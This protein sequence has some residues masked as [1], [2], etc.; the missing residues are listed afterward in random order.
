MTASISVETSLLKLVAARCSVE[1]VADAGC[2]C[3][4]LVASTDVAAGEVLLTLPWRWALTVEGAVRRLSA[5]EKSGRSLTVL[6]L[7]AVLELAKTPSPL[8]PPG[9]GWAL[10]LALLLLAELRE[11]RSPLARYV[12]TLPA[13]AG[14]LVSAIAL[15]PPAGACAALLT[16][17]QRDAFGPPALAAE[18]RAEETRQ[19]QLHAL[20]FG[21]SPAVTLQSFIWAGALVSSRALS[22]AA[23][24]GSLRCLLPSVDLCNHSSRDGVTASLRLRLRPDG[25]PLCVELASTRPLRRGGEVRFHY[26]PRPLRR[27]A[28]TYGFLPC[29]EGDAAELYEECAVCGEMCERGMLVEAADEEHGGILRLAEVRLG[30]APLLYVVRSGPRDAREPARCLYEEGSSCCMAPQ[31]EAELSLRLSRSAVAAARAMEIDEPR[32]A[33]AAE[34]ADAASPAAP[35]AAA[36]AGQLRVARLRLLLRT[37]AD[38]EAMAWLLHQSA[39]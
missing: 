31:Q 17:A 9:C 5:L 12:A 18:L 26:G 10:L 35:P 11:S 2:G 32:A 33:R 6:P 14:S 21:S 39:S 3:R 1:A 20:L 7:A 30:A 36:L 23:P 24:S 37:A 13:P 25:E 38:L 34:L 4:G 27:W 8:L 28:Q 15:G 22:L 19:A 29:E 16:A